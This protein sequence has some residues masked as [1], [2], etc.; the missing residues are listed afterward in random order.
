MIDDDDIW[1]LDV[2]D[3]KQWRTCPRVVYYRYCLPRIRPMTGK[4]EEGIQQHYEVEEREERRSLRAYGLAQGERFFH[5]TLRVPELRLVGKPDMVIV[6]P[7]Q[8]DPQAEAVVVDYKLSDRKV[9]TH[10][11]LQLAAYALLVEHAWGLVVAQG[12]V[13]LLPLRKA[14]P[15]KLTTR[16]KNQVRTTVADIQQMVYAGAM[17]PAPTRQGICVSCEFRRFCNDVL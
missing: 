9:G 5:T 15:V 7:A 4:M 8:D 6:T 13:Y 10:I 17:P 1:M 12:F 11:K 2:T 14:E 16:L 3:L